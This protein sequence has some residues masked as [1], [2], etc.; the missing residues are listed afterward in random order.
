VKPDGAGYKLH[1][2]PA[3]AVPFKTANAGTGDIALWPFYDA[4]RCPTLVV[5]G[6]LSDLLDHE[7][8]T[9]MAGRGPKARTV[10]IPDV[11]HAPMF[12]DAD[13]IAIV[14][15]FLLHD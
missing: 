1:Y 13:Q 9:A 2:D 6:A 5:R 7:T 10:E 3:I 4:V 8:L 11:G 12:M 15:E 14:R